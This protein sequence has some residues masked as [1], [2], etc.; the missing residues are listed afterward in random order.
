MNCMLVTWLV[1]FRERPSVGQDSDTRSRAISRVRRSG[2]GE[3]RERADVVCAY[4]CVRQGEAR[5]Y[6]PSGDVQ[7]WHNRSQILC[8]HFYFL[9]AL[10]F[11]NP[12]PLVASLSTG[13]W[14]P[15]FGRARGVEVGALSLAA[16]CRMCGSA[17][18]S[19]IYSIYSGAYY[20]R[21]PH[22][23]T[24]EYRYTRP[25]YLHRCPSR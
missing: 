4:S 13:R 25:E 22:S 20:L 17:W 23:N 9:F 21:S 11:S 6:A 14:D 3:T 12:A 19:A 8:I 2:N 10:F 24:Q 5:E 7:T 1:A 15:G 16:R 18:R